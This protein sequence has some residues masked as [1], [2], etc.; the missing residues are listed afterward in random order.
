MDHYQYLSIDDEHDVI[1]STILYFLGVH[2]LHQSLKMFLKIYYMNRLCETII[3]D[4][5]Q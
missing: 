4:I 2:L 3:D 1:N 5:L